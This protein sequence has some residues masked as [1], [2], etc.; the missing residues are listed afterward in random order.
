M[1]E[2]FGSFSFTKMCRPFS[3]KCI[4]DACETIPME[5]LMSYNNNDIYTRNDY[6]CDHYGS[7]CLNYSLI[8]FVPIV[9]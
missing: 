1:F 9:K 8:Y 2:I 3:D 6:Y 5:R 4:F 7:A